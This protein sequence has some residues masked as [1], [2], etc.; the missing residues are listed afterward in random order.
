VPGDTGG[1]TETARIDKREDVKRDDSRQH[2]GEIDA[3]QR[4]D[5][6]SEPFAD[7]LQLTTTAVVQDHVEKLT[8][9]STR[10]QI[11]LE[12]NVQLY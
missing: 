11:K 8:P 12:K 3:T 9:L 1:T 10:P 7:E 4:R 6:V 5:S 2:G